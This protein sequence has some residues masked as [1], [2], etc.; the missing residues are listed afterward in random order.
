MDFE[1]E[2]TFD[3]NGN[4]LNYDLEFS[5]GEFGTVTGIDEIKNR[6]ILGL[7]VYLGENFQ[8][9][10]YGVDYIRN[11]FGRDIL[12]PVVID[13]LKAAIL[14]TRGVTKLENFNLSIPDDNRSSKLTANVF[15]TQGE[16]N[17]LS[18]SINTGG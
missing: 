6:I 5:G 18:I 1:L 2:K 11:V 15:T 17:N 12:D 8:D 14:T 13:T 3:A 9:T 7:S 10:E 16:I 4:H